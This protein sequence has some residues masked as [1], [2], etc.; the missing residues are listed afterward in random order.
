[1]FAYMCETP[2]RKK[3]LINPFEMFKHTFVVYAYKES[4][5]TSVRIYWVLRRLFL[6]F[7]DGIYIF[8]C[9]K[10]VSQSSLSTI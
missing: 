2:E 5:I 4:E 6:S 1:M 9:Q 7:Q 3:K 8:V 10:W